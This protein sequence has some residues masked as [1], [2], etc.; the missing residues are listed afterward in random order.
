MH[1]SLPHF[2]DEN[3]TCFRTGD[4]AGG[5]SDFLFWIALRFA[6][7]RFSPS[8]LHILSLKF[9]FFTVT[10]FSVR[11][12][13][14][15]PSLRGYVRCHINMT[16]LFSAHHSSVCLSV[17][18]DKPILI[19]KERRPLSYP[20]DNHHLA[21]FLIY[22][23]HIVDALIL[24]W[25]PTT[26]GLIWLWPKFSYRDDWTI[27]SKWPRPRIDMR[28]R[29]EDYLPSGISQFEYHFSCHWDRIQYFL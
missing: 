10:R 19:S 2:L 17:L 27:V 12:R 20:Y 1:T 24:I 13:M 26:F 8:C 22:N 5:G 14:S 7:G 23:G 25:P 3:C 29:K 4:Q 21:Y 28:G 18:Y 9:S 6:W 11:A 15:L 16:I